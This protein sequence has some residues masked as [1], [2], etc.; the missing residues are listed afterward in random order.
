MTDSLRGKIKALQV[1]VPQG[2]SGRLLRES[3]FVFNYETHDRACEI[4]LGMPLRA[5]SRLGLASQNKRV[6]ISG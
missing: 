1:S 6:R 4:A 2:P 5:A 3:Q